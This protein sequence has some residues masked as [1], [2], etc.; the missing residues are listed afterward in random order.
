MPNR[1]PCKPENASLTQAH[2][3]SSILHHLIKEGALRTNIP[4]LSVF[5]EEMV[6]GETSF[7]QW[8]YELQTL[9][10]TYSES[11]LREGIQRSLKG[12]AADT[13][14]NMGPG[15]FLDTVIQKFSIIYGNVKSHDLLM[16]DFYRADHGG[17]ESV[18]S[19]AT[20]AEELLSKVRDKFPYQIPL[21]KVQNL[22]KERPFHGS[23]KSIWDSVKYHH[24]DSKVDYMIFQEECRRQGM[25]IE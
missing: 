18:T 4:K 20:Q 3:I 12:A 6:K 5:S 16:R 14:C 1:S 2:E 15:T 11:A 10:K 25:R 19:F 17:E 21:E 8:S 9:Q 22:L 23:C 13:V 24:A 7:E